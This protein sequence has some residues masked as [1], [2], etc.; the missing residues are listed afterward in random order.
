M[1][2]CPGP[3]PRPVPVVRHADALQRAQDVRSCVRHGLPAGRVGTVDTDGDQAFHPN[4]DDDNNDNRST[5]SSRGVR[6]QSRLAKIQYGC[7]HGCCYKWIL[8]DSTIGLEIIDAR[9]SGQ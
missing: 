2:V 9:H 1:R 3:A 4:E 5:K 6:V 8:A 7:S